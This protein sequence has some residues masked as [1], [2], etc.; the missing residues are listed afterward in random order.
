[1]VCASIQTALSQSLGHKGIGAGLLSAGGSAVVFVCVLVLDLG[2]GR[3][4]GLR[5]FGT[6]FALRV[7]FAGAVVLC[8]GVWTSESLAR[9]SLCH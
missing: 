1:M 6:A 3:V 4:R 9:G 5:Q 2:L 8:S 7:R